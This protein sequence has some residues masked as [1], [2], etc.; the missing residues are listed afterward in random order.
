MSLEYNGGDGCPFE[1]EMGTGVNHANLLLFKKIN[2]NKKQGTREKGEG[3]IRTVPV[4]TSGRM[5]VEVSL[6]SVRGL[7]QRKRGVL[8]WHIDH[9][10]EG[11]GGTRGKQRIPRSVEEGERCCWS[12]SRSRC[13]WR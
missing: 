6:C 8:E 13:G 7:R 10:R 1:S 5:R 4:G 12:G 2:N 3:R 9:L 11:R